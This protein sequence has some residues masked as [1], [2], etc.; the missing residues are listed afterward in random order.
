MTLRDIERY[1]RLR[2]QGDTAIPERLAMLHQQNQLLAERI[3][4]LQEQ[5]QFLAHKINTYNTQLKEPKPKTP[6]ARLPPANK[7]HKPSITFKHRRLRTLK[8]KLLNNST[9]PNIGISYEIIH[10]Y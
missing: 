7:L 2:A 1:S 6:Q 8:W 3:R 10:P 4:K 5:H 9:E